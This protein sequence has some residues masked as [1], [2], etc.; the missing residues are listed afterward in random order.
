MTTYLSPKEY[1]LLSIYSILISF[2][3]AFIGMNIQANISKNFFKISKK[4]L[5]LYIGNILII[6]LITFF[7][8]FILTFCVLFFKNSIFSIPTEWVLI[9]PIISII[10]IVNELNLTI[11]RNEQKAYMF[12]IFEISN[13]FIKMS[14][15]ILFLVVFS[16][17]WYSQVL[18]ILIGSVIFFFVSILYM[19]KKNYIFL[20]MNKDKIKS[21]L[22]I[23]LPLIPHMMGGVIIAMSDR[24]FIERMVGLDAVGIYSVGYMFGMV[25]LLFT[26][27][28]IKAWSP[29]FYKL[30]ANPTHNKKIKIVKYT[31]LYIFGTFVLSIFISFIADFMLPYFVDIKFYDAKDFIL[32]I[33]LGYAIHGVYKIFFPY[34]VHL[35][36]TSF[37]ALSTTTAAIINLVLNYFFIK[38]FGA[39][40]ATYATII[41]FLVS[42][43]LVFW[44][45]HKYI[46]MPWLYI[47]LT[48][49]G[50]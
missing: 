26:D 27:A 39:L 6:L 48:K 43:V 11:L 5:S 40:G 16:F 49:E 32:W 8:Y 22:N 13:T 33:S 36:K 23:S 28:F 1:G 30:L 12:G 35:N 44:Y 21:I 31:Y 38:Y 47:F 24:I 29:W 4:E 20:K 46:K 41:A 9:I 17:G 18:G 50:R 7:A 14:L 42:A 19:K 10:T 37:L 15:T 45:Q 25:V 2:Y 3:S 34:L